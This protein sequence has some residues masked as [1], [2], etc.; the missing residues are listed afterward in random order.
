MAYVSAPLVAGRVAL[1]LAGQ[2]D[3]RDGIVTDAITGKKYNDRDTLSGRAILRAQATD[4]LEII[5]SGDYTRQRTALTLGHATAPL[6]GF[7]YNATFTAVTPFS[8]HRRGTLWRLMTTRRRP[9]SQG[10]E[11][12]K[13]DHWG[14]SGTINYELSDALTLT[15]ITAYRKLSPDYYVDIDATAAEVG[16][17]FVGVRQ[18]QFSEELQLKYA[19]DRVQGVFGLYYMNETDPLRIRKPMQT[20][21]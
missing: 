5:L 13:L 8:H 15:S 18:K 2:L 20:A 17:V 4:A 14:L 16:D 3:K 1:S 19:S 10:N 7:N 12:Q 11:G 21:I 9:A 6:V